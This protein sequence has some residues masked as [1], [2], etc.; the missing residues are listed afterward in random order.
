MRLGLLALSLVLFAA[1]PC[2]ADEVFKAS[3]PLNVVDVLPVPPKDGSD[4]QKAELTALHMIEMHRTAAE[5]AQAQS[6]ARTRNVFL[7]ATIFGARFNQ[8][9]LPLTAE[10]SADIEATEKADFASVKHAFAR[11]RP[12]LF[13][14]TLHPVCR[15]KESNSYPS[16][17]ATS[18]YLE[19]LVLASMLPEDKDAIFA[20]AADFARS[21]LVCGV[22]YPSDV[23]AG[24]I[25]AYAL[26][27]VISQDSK[28][29]A[30]R[31]A[32]AAELRKVLGLRTA[33]Q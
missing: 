24:K 6:D 18:G 33:A 7:F 12:Y 16:G 29:Q 11:A 31:R 1:L 4:L 3:A 27:G 30:A 19:A 9:R 17:H 13:D 22:H 8:D 26:F 25:V 20:R 32:A 23:E 15:T 14:K 10:L 21:R 2:A 5:I 28:F